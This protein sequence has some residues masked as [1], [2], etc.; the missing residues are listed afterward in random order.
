MLA[1]YVCP[2]ARLD[3]SD[4]KKSQMWDTSYCHLITPGLLLSRDI[5]IRWHCIG[6][7]WQESS[8]TLNGIGHFEDEGDVLLMWDRLSLFDPPA[9]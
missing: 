4:R 8:S 3:A 9:G 2:R 7:L 6:S 5:R 1:A